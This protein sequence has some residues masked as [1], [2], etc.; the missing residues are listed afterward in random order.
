MNTIANVWEDVF[1]SG[2]PPAWLTEFEGDPYGA[3]DALL[4]R[5][6]YHGPLNLAEPEDLVIDWVLLIGEAGD[7]ATRLDR[8]MTA[9]VER[10]WGSLGSGST[11]GLA[12]A[13]S[14]LPDVVAAT[15][16]L[17]GTARALRVRFG[18]AQEYLG[19][20][21]LSPSQDPLGRYLGAVARYQPDRSLA[22]FWWQ[23]CELPDRVPFYHAPHAIE[24]LR[25]LPPLEEEETGGF[26]L[27]LVHGLVKLSVALARRREFPAKQ[28][29]EMFFAVARRTMA[30]YPFPERWEASLRPLFP[31]LP[32]TPAAWF[33]AL[34][35]G[36]SR[37]SP[38]PVRRSVQKKESSTRLTPHPLWAERAGAIA[39]VLGRRPS[40][41]IDEAETLLK[42]QRAYAQLTGDSYFLVRS[43]CRFASVIA[44]RT[45]QEALKWAEEARLWEPS[46]AFSWN[47]LTKASRHARGPEAALQ[48]AW[49]TV[50][51]FPEDVAAWSTLGEVLSELRRLEEAEE[52][53]RQARK[54]FPT[55]EYSW[56][57]LAEVLKDA[58]RFE[59]AEAVYREASAKFKDSA[60]TWNGLAD[61]LK[62]AGRLEEAESLYRRIIALERFDTPV[63]WAG[64][65]DVLKLRWK[66]DEAEEAYRNAVNRFPEEPVPPVGLASVL[67]LKGADHLT[68]ALR[69]VEAVLARD[70]RNAPALEEQVRILDALGRFGQA[71]RVRLAAEDAKRALLEGL[72]REEPERDE[73]SPPGAEAPVQLGPPRA[74][75]ERLASDHPGSEKLSDDGVRTGRETPRGDV[76]PAAAPPGESELWRLV[77]RTSEARFLRRWAWRMQAGGD[78]QEARRLRERARQQ[79]EGVLHARAFDGRAAAEMGLLLLAQDR[80]DEAHRFVE[81]KLAELPA[82]PATALVL[83]RARR[84][85]AEQLGARLE[86]ESEAVL[87][88]AARR[89][90]EAD[91]QL[92]PLVRITLGRGYLALRDGD[93]RVGRA[94]QQFQQLRESI[95]ELC[96]KSQNGF[97]R[98]WSGEVESS[99]F[100]SINVPSGLG[101]RD[102]ETI[103]ANLEN[104]SDW[105]DTLEEDLSFRFSRL[106]L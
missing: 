27:D 86:N 104:A 71:S 26:R 68:D 94:M 81:E 34:V 60:F 102:L 8:T 12:G 25:G 99:V 89:L 87:V 7:F 5:R 46:D 29:K 22:P 2:N 33:A 30:A 14:R 73:V 55:Q 66:L 97:W 98:W 103:E 72:A 10:N 37:P 38:E 61:V 54:R 58:G 95:T 16:V 4:W 88:D 13:W 91:P 53:Y 80:L 85:R 84:L 56:N 57:G 11:A 74:P 77:A 69:Y 45:P 59:E 15:G 32:D 65:G 63:A 101:V 41:A 49:T 35:P 52:I 18:E 106:P 96:A 3:V 28:M 6:F 31:G 62:K 39:A 70:P 23:L 83:V 47:T 67:R 105:V 93:L 50:E 76:L 24:G 79:L 20:L 100:A 51:R 75:I 36:M 44:P 42:E 17:T 1:A 92:E 48:I 64:L 40:T 19:G 90:R 9:W 82:S 78:Q 21:S 43:L